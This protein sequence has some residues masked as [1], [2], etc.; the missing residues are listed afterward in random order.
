MTKEVSFSYSVFSSI[1]ELSKEDKILMME[2]EKALQQAYAKYSGFNVGAALY[3][4]NGK[5]MSANNQE[6]MALPSSLCAERVLLYYCKANFPTHGVK[7]IAI[8]VKSS[9]EIIDKPISPCGSCRQVMLEY[10]RMQKSNIEVLLKGQTGEVYLIKSVS[11][12]LPLAFNTNAINR[13]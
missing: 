7:K 4:D 12:L 6:N 1:D 2:S 9:I 8:S 10:E 11:D 13:L 5:M 3:L